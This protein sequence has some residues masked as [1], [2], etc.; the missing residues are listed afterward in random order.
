MKAAEDIV[1]LYKDRLEALGPDFARMQLVSSV[2]D[3]DIVIPLPEMH[4]HEKAATPNLAQQ[5]LDQMAKRISSVMP[6]V[7]YPP[8]YSSDAADKIARERTQLTYGWWAKNRMRKKLSRR[9]RWF[10]GYATAP[11]I[12]KPG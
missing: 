8:L 7:S 10:L 3:G 5:G 11:V 1:Q 9:S 6:I 12:I 4:K 2:I